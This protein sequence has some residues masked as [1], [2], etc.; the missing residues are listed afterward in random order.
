MGIDDVGIAVEAHDLYAVPIEA[1][2]HLRDGFP[3]R[4]QRIE[5]DVGEAEVGDHAAEPFG[6]D[7]GHRLFHGQMGVDVRH[8]AQMQVLV[9]GGRPIRGSGAQGPRPQHNGR[10]SLEPV[11]AVERGA[12]EIVFDGWHAV[13]G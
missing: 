5:L 12:Q 10:R 13:H 6:L 9:S 11:A 8:D 2:A 1:V 3:I 4:P 7:L